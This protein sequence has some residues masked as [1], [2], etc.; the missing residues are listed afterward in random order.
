MIK[1]ILVVD[2][3][4]KRIMARYYGAPEFPTGEAETTFEK[5]LYD[6]TMRTN[7]KN[8]GAPARLEALSGASAEPV[9]GPR[10]VATRRT[11]PCSA[12][13][14]PQPRSACVLAAEVIM[15]DNIVT[16]YR[17]SADVWFYVTQLRLK[18]ATARH[19]GLLGRRTLE[20]A[21]SRH[22]VE[23]TRDPHLALRGYGATARPCQHR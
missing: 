5:K 23:V 1:A 7:A 2:G 4:G 13:R 17:N 12:P 8:E 15:F 16:V 14:P 3:D 20:Q 21:R 9:S 10:A 19:T 6:K 22:Q 18:S 11:P